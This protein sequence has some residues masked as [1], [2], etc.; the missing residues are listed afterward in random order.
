MAQT[1]VS[2]AHLSEEER[3]RIRKI[4][5]R[6]DVPIEDSYDGVA[7]DE[8]VVYHE[9]VIS[10]GNTN[11][12]HLGYLQDDLRDL[13]KSDDIGYWD[14]PNESGFY[15]KHYHFYHYPEESTNASRQPLE[16]GFTYDYTVTQEDD[17]WWMGTIEVTAP[18]LKDYTSESL[19][20]KLTEMSTV[21]ADIVDVSVWN[22][23]A[24][25][26]VEGSDSDEVEDGVEDV[27]D[28]LTQ[29]LPAEL[30]SDRQ[31]GRSGDF[32]Y[33]YQVA[34]KKEPSWRGTVQATADWFEN[35]TSETLKTKLQEMFTQAGRL[36]DVD[37]NGHD[38]RI[39]I[40]A[41]DEGAAEYTAKRVVDS[42]YVLSPNY[43]NSSKTQV[44]CQ[45]HRTSKSS[46]KQGLDAVKLRASEDWQ[47]FK[48]YE[49]RLIPKDGDSW[50]KFAIYVDAPSE[51]AVKRYYQSSLADA[52]EL[53][54]IIPKKLRNK[55]LLNASK[56][57]VIDYAVKTWED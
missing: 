12:T 20:A 36:V 48:T 3:S 27:I 54:K 52:Y 55:G 37:V 18:G 32:T 13:E 5:E 43:V 23:D 19:A 40:E 21:T 34:Q 38:A 4:F 6:N 41:E 29:L 31:V 35:Y 53:D 57:D 10:S 7:E 24:Q 39:D 14:E 30:N 46:Q 16:G 28:S 56:Q 50:D 33:E 11:A 45:V 51:D 25:I 47:S 17:D 44:A 26:V 2:T 1:G 15:A 22:H 9:Y 8:G 49:V 42:L